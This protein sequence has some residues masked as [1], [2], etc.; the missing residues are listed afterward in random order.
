MSDQTPPLLT[1]LEDKGIT[2]QSLIES[3]LEMYVPHPG[4]E[5]EEKAKALIKRR[6]SRHPNRCK[7][8]NP[9]RRCIP[10]PRR[11]R[12]RPNPRVIEREIFGQT[13]TRRRRT[14]RHSHSHIHRRVKRHVRVRAI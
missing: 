6:I 2:L 11:S 5:T 7:R 13:R 14:H 1:Y 4:V 8:L 9:Y 10:C 12:E 3:A